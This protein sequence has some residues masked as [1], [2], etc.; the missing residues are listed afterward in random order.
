VAQTQRVSRTLKALSRSP[1]A[2]RQVI[3]ICEDV[4]LGF[5]SIKEVV[6]IHEKK[7]TEKGLQNHTKGF[8][9]R[10]DELQRHYKR[11]PM[12]AIRVR[13]LLTL[14]SIS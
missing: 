10:I 1:I 5:R 4:H 8:T 7:V 14:A 9:T 2:I 6:D 11:V 3:A 12:S 13:R